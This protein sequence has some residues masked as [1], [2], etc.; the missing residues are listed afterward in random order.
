MAEIRRKLVIVGDGAC[1][2]T[3]LLMCVAPFALPTPCLAI[4]ATPANLTAIDPLTLSPVFS[5]RA[6]SPR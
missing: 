2:K 6:H 5:P 3:C 1:G 4:L